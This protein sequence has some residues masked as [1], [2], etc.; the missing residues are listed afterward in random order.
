VTD[1]S[2]AAAR[3]ALDEIRAHELADPRIDPRNGTAW[4]LGDAVAPRAVVLLHGL[5]NCPRQYQLLGE[6]LHARG[7][8]VIA[9]RFP[10]HG[11]RDRMTDAL[12]QLRAT[13]MEATALRAVALAAACGE[14]V[15]VAGISIGASLAGWLA[16][17]VALDLAVAVAPFCGIRELPG[18][19]NDK[20]GATLRAAPNAFS[21]WDPRAKQKQ[22][23][24]H[25]YP[26]FATRSIGESLKLSSDIAAR[27]IPAR[28]ARRVALVL[29]G[30]DPIVNNA[31]AR[32]RFAAL[33]ARGVEV[34]EIVWRDVPHIHDLVEPEI[35]QARTDLIYPRLI[36]LLE[37]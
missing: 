16:A 34:E 4:W 28:H 1:G 7:H 23:P 5:S 26:R 6:Q 9:P 3:A 19:L 13:A 25:G 10:H 14:R 24:A 8:A 36:E 35:P 33:R 22:P 17:R 12:A 18:S 27:P 21:W 2:L 29:N 31:H 11:Y 15:A 20:L 32:R 30:H 37:R